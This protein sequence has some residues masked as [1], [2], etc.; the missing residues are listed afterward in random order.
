MAGD[1]NLP[2]GNP[3]LLGDANLDGA[4]DGSDFNTWN[5]H[6]YSTSGKWSMGDFN[7]DGVTDGADFNIWN[8]NKFT[9]ADAA[10]TVPEPRVVLTGVVF[11]AGMLR[12]RRKAWFS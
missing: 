1:E 5:S 3:Y 8:T 7:V 6:K 12:S 11:L 4:V 10:V 2:S 9:S